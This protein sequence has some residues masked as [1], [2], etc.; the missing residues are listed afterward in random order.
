MGFV[1]L[2]KIVSFSGALKHQDRWLAMCF[3]HE[4]LSFAEARENEDCRRFGSVRGTLIFGTTH[5]TLRRL[6]VRLTAAKRISLEGCFW[7]GV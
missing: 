4:M 7:V 1:G 2:E 5:R 3:V 6:S